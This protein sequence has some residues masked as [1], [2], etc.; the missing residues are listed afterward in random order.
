MCRHRNIVGK[1]LQPEAMLATSY[2]KRTTTRQRGRRSRRCKIVLGNWNETRS[3]YLLICLP[4][5]EP[6]AQ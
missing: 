3:L 4:R 6:T 1:V 5:L 2:E